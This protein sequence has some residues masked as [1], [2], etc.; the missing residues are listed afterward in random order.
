M[1]I[2]VCVF[3]MGLMNIAQAQT[4]GNMPGM[5]PPMSPFSPQ[6]DGSQTDGSQTFDSQ[7]AGNILADTYSDGCGSETDKVRKSINAFRTMVSNIEDSDRCKAVKDSLD[8]IPDINAI[9][10]VVSAKSALRY[11]K[12]KEREL[13]DIENSLNDKLL[14]PSEKMQLKA[15]QMEIK[16]DLTVF[17]QRNILGAGKT[18]QQIKANSAIIDNIDQYSQALGS[19]IQSKC[20]KKDSG[21]TTQALLSL[22]GLTGL[23]LSSTPLGLGLSGAVK[24]TR[25][26]FAIGKKYDTKG[27]DKP[28]MAMG[29]GCALSSLNQ[30][31][32]ELIKNKKL[33]DQVDTEA[34]SC[35]DCSNNGIDRGVASLKG[36]LDSFTPRETEDSEDFVTRWYENQ[37]SES[38]LKSLSQLSD[39]D[40]DLLEERSRA[41]SRTKAKGFKEKI[42]KAETAYRALEAGYDN[43][44]TTDE[45]MSQL[46]EDF[47]N[48]F[49]LLTATNPETQSQ[50]SH[51][52]KFIDYSNKQQIQRAIKHFQN[53]PD[54]TPQNIAKNFNAEKINTVYEIF[55]I[56]SFIEV[57]QKQDDMRQAF[58]GSHQKMK[59]FSKIFLKDAKGTLD[60][61]DKEMAVTNPSDREKEKS[62]MCLKLLGFTPIDKNINNKCKNASVKHRGQTFKYMDFINLGHEDRVCA[63]QDFFICAET[64]E[65]KSPACLDH[66]NR[67]AKAGQRQ[68]TTRQ[69]TTTKTNRE[70]WDKGG[71]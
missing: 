15:K 19:A 14:P 52:K 65:P 49:K 43:D 9:Q 47:M 5:Q 23:M 25:N 57:A 70:D 48:S 55:N 51:F 41:F 30:G 8:N 29:L 45:E 38:A 59:S 53:N 33:I 21:A 54:N 64:Q 42:K 62:K 68:A 4:D 11:L 26:L 67:L 28:L 40:N 6:T 46:K 18:D 22:T 16:Q 12:Q 10:K 61:I 20:L 27:L 13:R 56:S 44:D 71:Q 63:V 36:V 32:C 69:L 60:Y 37:E 35:I 50:V 58:D 1:I 24:L 7:P 34:Q 66:T 3:F 2:F 31:H 17:K 39:L